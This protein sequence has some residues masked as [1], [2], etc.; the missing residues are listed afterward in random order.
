M[1]TFTFSGV[2]EVWGDVTTVKLHA[3]NDLQLVMQRFPILTLKKK[4]KKKITIL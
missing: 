3:F 2:D 1:S 4:K